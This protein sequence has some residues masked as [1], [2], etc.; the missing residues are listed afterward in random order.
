MDTPRLPLQEDLWTCMFARC[1]AHRRSHGMAVARSVAASVFGSLG[2]LSPVAALELLEQDAALLD[3]MIARA[4]E[5]DRAGTA[6]PGHGLR[7]PG[8][9][10]PADAGK[11]PR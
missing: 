11:A 6:A 9:A 8:D 4:L 2:R 7:P 10:T 5:D 1:L 3:A